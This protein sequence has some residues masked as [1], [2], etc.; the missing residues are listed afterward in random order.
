MII[1][2]HGI[3]CF[4]AQFGNTTL[5]FNPTSKDSQF[6]SPH[7]GAD[8]ALS[9]TNY[10]DFNGFES[11]SGGDGTPFSISGP[12]E[13]E[14]KGVII[15]GLLSQTG[16]GGE[17]RISTVYKVTLE[18]INLLFLGPINSPELSNDIKE[19][20]GDIDILCVPIGGDGTLS[21]SEAYKVS[22]EVAPHI[23]IPMHYGD[24]GNKD[25]LSTFLKEQG[26]KE[27]EAQEKL[28][29]KPKGLENKE[30]EVVVLSAK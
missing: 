8:I 22:V 30:G 1:T 9:T 25:A 23:V 3:E 14:V 4:K 7:F 24:V 29:V 17:E 27:T 26:A 11:I 18:N 28:T 21:P 16:Y 6:K 13:Y 12:G 20:L 10:P 2:Y 15:T 19:L 5:A